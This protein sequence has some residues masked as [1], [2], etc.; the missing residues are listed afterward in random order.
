MNTIELVAAILMVASFTV[1]VLAAQKSLAVYVEKAGGN[2]E[3]Q[4]DR[5][6]CTALVNFFYASSGHEMEEGIECKA[7]A[8]GKE[9]LPLLAKIMTQRDGTASIFTVKEGMHYG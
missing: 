8:H 2:M 3:E 6:H 1:F 7:D 4:F 9:S 5:T